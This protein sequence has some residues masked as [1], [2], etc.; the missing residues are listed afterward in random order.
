MRTGVLFDFFS[1]GEYDKNREFILT[2]SPSMDILI[3]SNLERLI[4][5]VSGD[6]PVKT[7]QLMQ[8]LSEKGSYEI[9]EEMR[10]R[11]SDFCAAMRRT[12]ERCVEDPLSV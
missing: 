5:R 7:A 8:A 4:Y 11:L 1:T 6:D 2:S 9:T 3:S 12:V 10:E